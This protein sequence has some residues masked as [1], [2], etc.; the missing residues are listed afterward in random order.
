M[1]KTLLASVVVGL[2]LTLVGC[3]GGGGGSS[4]GSNNNT[5]TTPVPTSPVAELEKAVDLEISNTWYQFETDENNMFTHYNYNNPTEFRFTNNK[6]YSQVVVGAQAYPTYFTANAT[7]KYEGSDT[8][9]N[10]GSLQRIGKLKNKEVVVE[11]D[12]DGLE[13]S[14]LLLTTVPYTADVNDPNALTITHKYKIIDLEGQSISESLNP[15]G[16]AYVNSPYISET[17]KQSEYSKPLVTLLDDSKGFTAT[18]FTKGAY[19][20]SAVSSTANQDYFFVKSGGSLP[21]PTFD[22]IYKDEYTVTK[23]FAAHDGKTGTLYTV[24]AEKM[25]NGD[26]F[27]SAIVLEDNKSNYMTAVYHIGQYFPQGEYN[28]KVAHAKYID[29]V[30]G[31]FQSR[32]GEGETLDPNLV[33]EMEIYKEY[34]LTGCDLYNRAGRDQARQFLISVNNNI[35]GEY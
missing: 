5:P 10:I 25:Y 19:C 9:D 23:D 15:A 16:Y 17:E 28:Y 27:D 22:N 4:K 6:I 8:I 1:K 18:K 7:Y 24:P 3:G 30:L 31:L 21:S 11:K 2:G 26:T 29:S 12:E 20:L 13:T 34:A 14:Y 33:G 32:L 35:V